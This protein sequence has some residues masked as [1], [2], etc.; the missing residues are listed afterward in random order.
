MRIIS[1]KYKGKKIYE[2]LVFKTSHKYEKAGKY[3]V[4][5]KVTDVFGNDGIVIKDVVIGR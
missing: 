5:V 2:D 1:G 3:K 4:A